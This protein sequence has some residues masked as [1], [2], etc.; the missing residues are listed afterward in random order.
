MTEN[1]SHAKEGQRKKREKYSKIPLKSKLIF[2]EKVLHQNAS[3]RD[4]RSMIRRSLKASG[5]SI[6]QPRPSSGTTNSSKKKRMRIWFRLLFGTSRKASD[7]KNGVLISSYKTQETLS[8]A[9]AG[10]RVVG[11]KKCL[12][13]KK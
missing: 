1:L 5:S 9:L 10:D 2:Y 13:F 8:P 4:V 12:L 11:H 6:R 3:L 7:P